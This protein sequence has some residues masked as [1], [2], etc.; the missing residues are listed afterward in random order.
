MNDITFFCLVAKTR[1]AQKAYYADKTKSAEKQAK[2]IKSK[3]LEA[4]LDAEIKRRCAEVYNVD[5]MKNAWKLFCA[6]SDAHK[7]YME[8]GKLYAGD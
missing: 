3:Q 6:L 2:L 8:I 1:A 5:E 7:E 4:Q